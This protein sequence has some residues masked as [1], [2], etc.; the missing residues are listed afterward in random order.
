[1]DGGMCM[2]LLR[3]ICFEIVGAPKWVELCVCEYN[4]LSMY[5]HMMFARVYTGVLTT[6]GNDIGD[7]RCRKLKHNARSQIVY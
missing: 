1:M 3:W 5:T 6:N 4:V 7:M 2:I